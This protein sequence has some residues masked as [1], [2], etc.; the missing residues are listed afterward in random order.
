MLWNSM[1]LTDTRI[2]RER[3]YGMGFMLALAA[4]FF[5]AL[6]APRFLAYWPGIAG[7]VSLA[8]YAFIFRARPAVPRALL[9]TVAAVLFVA[10]LSSFWALDPEGALERAGKMALVLLSGTMMVSAALSV[11]VTVLRPY[12]CY[13]FYAA[14]ASSLLC[15]IDLAAGFPFYRLTQGLDAAALVEPAAL[16]RS[17]IALLCLFFTALAFARLEK[18]KKMLACLFVAAGAMV[19]VTDSQSAQLGF[20]F[21]L[22]CYTFFP[23]SHKRMWRVAGGLLAAGV[24]V[25]PWLAPWMFSTLAAPLSDMPFLGKGGGFAGQRLEIWDEVARYAMQSPLY[26]HGI[27]ATRAVEAFESDQIY[28]Q[29]LTELHPHNFAVQLW[30]E[31]GVIGAVLGATFFVFIFRK[32]EVLDYRQ[33]QIALPAFIIILVAATF[34]YGLWQSWLLGLM[35]CALAVTITGIRLCADQEKGDPIHE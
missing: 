30:I 16:N 28:R 25:T 22:L 1:T 14:A 35:L 21:A 11:P 19:I 26:G 29:S 17:V 23:Y 20:V 24:L 18:D 3:L 6:T 2:D 27:E 4:S 31:F 5:V 12:T 13:V 32:M 33:A 8:G 9:I 15:A 10:G 34:G 7:L